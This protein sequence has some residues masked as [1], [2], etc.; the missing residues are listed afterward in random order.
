[1]ITQANY[2]KSSIGELTRVLPRN[3]K[4]KIADSTKETYTTV[5]NVWSGKQY[6]KKVVDAII[7]EYNKVMRTQKEIT[8]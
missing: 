7:K 2:S 8:A 6:K 1:M 3:T 4:Q 5:A